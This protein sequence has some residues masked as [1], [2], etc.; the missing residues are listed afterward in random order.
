MLTAMALIVSCMYV[1]KSGK[2]RSS[3]MYGVT[4]EK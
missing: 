4:E 2:M 3:D 1:M